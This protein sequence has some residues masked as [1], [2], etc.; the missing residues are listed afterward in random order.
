MKGNNVLD[1]VVARAMM[2]ACPGRVDEGYGDKYFMD[3][4]GKMTEKVIEFVNRYD[5][6]DIPAGN[7]A[8]I[9]TFPLDLGC[10][11][12]NP[13][14]VVKND[15]G[16]AKFKFMFKYL[17]GERTGGIPYGGNYEG[18]R[19]A[20]E[21]VQLI[22]NIPG[23]VDHNALRVGIVHEITHLVDDMVNI[24]KGYR[25]YHYNR[26]DMKEYG[27]DS[28]IEVLLYCLWDTTEFNAW[29]A[30]HQYNGTGL[31]YTHVLMSMLSF[32]NDINDEKAWEKARDYSNERNDLGFNGT[33]AQFKHYFIKTT[34]RLIK[35][36]VR[37]YY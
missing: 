1:E 14:N 24:V 33:P 19:T 5:D 34:F 2:L 30:S 20:D 4:A 3:I 13:G 7:D 26:A 29:K 16:V 11:G 18:L 10:I 31:D 23:D 9:L 28:A 22:L 17:P 32:A 25:L 21:G 36:M 15:K 27:L 8:Y 37:K 35:K 6:G 12:I